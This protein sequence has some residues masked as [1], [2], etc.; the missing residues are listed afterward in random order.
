MAAV[1]E[2]AKPAHPAQTHPA[3]NERRDVDKCDSF[4]NKIPF[5]YT[6]ITLLLHNR[7]VNIEARFMMGLYNLCRL[8]FL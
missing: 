5:Y 4:I 6:L 1:A 7:I 3:I 8:Y 2:A